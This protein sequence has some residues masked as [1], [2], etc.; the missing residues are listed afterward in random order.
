MIQDMSTVW[1]YS[2]SPNADTP[3]H[4]Y[5]TVFTG[6]NEDRNG[7]PILATVSLSY[8]TT[9]STLGAGAWIRDVTPPFGPPIELHD[10]AYNSYFFDQ[11]LSVTFGLSA[12]GA[13]AY[14]QGNV[15]FY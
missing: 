3:S 6:N 9:L 8:L 2:Y 7:R 1:L 11:A 12:R 13:E 14:A 15:F 5:Y 10:F 4:A